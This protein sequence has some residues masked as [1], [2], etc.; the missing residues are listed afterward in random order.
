MYACLEVRQLLDEGRRFL[1]VLRFPPPIK[2]THHDRTLHVESGVKHQSINY[3]RT[4]TYIYILAKPVNQVHCL[5]ASM[6]TYIQYILA[7]TNHVKIRISQFSETTEVYIER[8]I[9]KVS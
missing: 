1:R 3:T 9:Y 5:Q 2:L 4:Y 7:Y 8:S 6:P